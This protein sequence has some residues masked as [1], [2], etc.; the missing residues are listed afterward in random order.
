MLNE[1]CVFLYTIFSGLIALCIFLYGYVPVFSSQINAA[2]RQDLPT[3]IDGSSIDPERIYHS[4]VQKLVILII[5]SLSIDFFT[6]YSI[7]K[8]LPHV[9]RLIDR[10]DACLVPYNVP[11][12]T[13][14]I[15]KIKALATGTRSSFIE[16]ILTFSVEELEM[17]SIFRQAMDNK[18][19]LILHGPET[20]KQ[21]FPDSFLRFKT[22]DTLIF[23]YSEAVII[24]VNQMDENTANRKFNFFVI[25][26]TNLMILTWVLATGMSKRGTSFIYMTTAKGFVIANVAVLMC[27]NSYIMGTQ[28]SFL[29]R[30]FSASTEV[31]ENSKESIDTI[32]SRI[33]LATSK[34]KNMNLLLVF[35]MSGTIVHATSLLELSY[36]KQ[37]KWVWFFLWTSMCFFII[38]KHIGTIYQSETPETSH[39]LLNESQNVKHGVITVVSSILIMH[40]TIM[41]YTTVD[42]WVSHNDNRLCTSLCLI[43][44]LVLL[45]FTCSIYYE[46]FTSAVDK[47]ITCILLGLIC[48]SIYALNAAQG[49]VLLPKYPES[50]GALEILFFWLT[51]ISIMGYGI[52]FCTIQTCCKGMSNSKQLI[53]VAITCWA[54]FTALLTRSHKVLLISVEMLFGQAISDVFKKHNQ[55]SILSHVWLGHLFF[56]HQGYTYSLDSIDMATGLLFSKKMCTLMYEV[57]LV[58][59]TFSAPVLSYL[60]CIHGMLSNNSKTSTSQGISEVNMIFGYCRFFLMAVY[61]LGMFVHRHNEWLWNILSPKLLYEIV[62]TFLI[63][64]VMIS[65]QVTG[66][67]HDLSVKLR[68]PFTEPM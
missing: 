12:P 21:L 46:P 14:T 59:N 33:Q 17:D 56:H 42:N 25:F 35:L 37:E 63:A 68:M 41:A 7:K 36:I 9:T 61:L 6:D 31:A 38:Y 11:S 34:H 44:G 26:I 54:C 15:R 27:C 49:N 5:D 22:I 2:S 64:F 28:K 20:W 50:D 62:Y 66:L 48:C 8:N 1:K 19:Q 30:L 18:L 29:T 52:G 47:F 53:A 60:I 16:S 10:G 3:K 57:L 51:W 67:L 32:S 4:D 58:I 39:E 65:A 40:R 24:L 45:G 23:D 55:C 13:T 43:L